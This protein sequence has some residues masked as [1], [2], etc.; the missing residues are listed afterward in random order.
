MHVEMLQS[1]EIN[2]DLRLV[3]SV[4]HDEFDVLDVKGGS[5]ISDIVP[6]NVPGY[7]VE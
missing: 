7:G 6:F 5:I 4:G 3:V 2:D 1:W